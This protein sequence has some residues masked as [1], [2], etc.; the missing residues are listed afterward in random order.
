MSPWW[1]PTCR[2]LITSDGSMMMKLKG[3]GQCSRLVL[4]WIWHTEADTGVCMIAKLKKGGKPL[5]YDDKYDSE[6]QTLPPCMAFIMTEGGKHCH[7]MWRW[8]WYREIN[9][10]IVCDAEYDTERQS[11]PFCVM[12][13]T[14]EMQTRM[15]VCEEMMRGMSR[16]SKQE[17]RHNRDF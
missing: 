5:F 10:A 16:C 8:G 11:L 9:S 13:N 15:E 6:R 1:R 12:L 17:W 4:C 3:R 2:G 14:T 7:L